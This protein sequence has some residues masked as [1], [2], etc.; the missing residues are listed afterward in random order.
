MAIYSYDF[1]TLADGSV[2]VTEK[3]NTGKNRKFFQFDNMA[4]FQDWLKERKP[5]NE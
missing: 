5:E 2:Q 3:D 1:R 4:E